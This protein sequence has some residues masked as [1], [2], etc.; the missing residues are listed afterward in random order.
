MNHITIFGL[1]ARRVAAACLLAGSFAAAP[2]WSDDRLLAEAI[3]AVRESTQKE[4]AGGGLQAI[5][6]KLYQGQLGPAQA[7]I[8][9]RTLRAI[10]T[11]EQYA[12]YIARVLLPLFRQDAAAPRVRAA[13]TESVQALTL[14]GMQRLPPERQ[15]AFVQHMLNLVH[16]L[17]P[18][19][20]AAIFLGQVP[21]AAMSLLERRYL[22]TLEAAP[23]SQVM[24]LYAEASISELEGFPGVRS[25]SAVQQKAGEQAL[26]ES[27]ARRLR[28]TMSP[29][30]VQRVLRNMK[31]APEA[32]VCTYMR[33]FLHGALDLPEPQR[34]WV[35]VTLVQ[36]FQ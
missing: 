24:T 11:N 20:C 34:S 23:F 12:E 2:A 18:E 27:V 8:A 36:K 29:Q 13:I 6:E 7:E 14:K 5:V 22:A 4:L 25:I 3:Q 17:T 26:V 32:D 28:E 35:L 21:E 15:A 9:E 10:M 33:N 19:G 31:T 16:S 1:R 30:A